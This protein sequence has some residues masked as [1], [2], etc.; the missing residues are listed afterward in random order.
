[1]KK[2]NKVQLY[3]SLLMFSLV[4]IFGGLATIFDRWSEGLAVGLGMM[5]FA[6][7]G[8]MLLYKD[9]I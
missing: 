6:G 9:K 4:V 5:L 1:M 7:V 2:S 3:K 8:F